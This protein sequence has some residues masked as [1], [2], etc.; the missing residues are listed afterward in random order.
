[1][2]KATAILITTEKEYPKGLVNFM[3][4][5]EV[6]IK[7]ECPNIYERYIQASK[8]RNDIVYVQDD[9]CTVDY[10]ELFKHYDGR[11]TNTMTPGHQQRYEPLGM[12]LVGWGC[13]FPKKILINMGKYASKYG[14]DAHMLRESD[15]IFTYLN[16][17]FNTIIMP[18]QDL[19]QDNRMSTTDPLHYVYIDQVREKLK[20]VV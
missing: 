20:N 13:F 18:H 3:D 12:T 8:A 9:D 6:I 5:D 4:F 14:V 19:P 10:K 2:I 11:I 17:P 1:M 16:Q 15:R 7:T